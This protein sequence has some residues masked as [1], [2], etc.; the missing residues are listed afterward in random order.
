MNKSS[1][2]DYNQNRV[3]HIA[4]ASPQSSQSDSDVNLSAKGDNTANLSGHK[5][6]II[7]SDQRRGCSFDSTR[8]L[9]LIQGVLAA[10]GPESKLKQEGNPCKG[11]NAAVQRTIHRVIRN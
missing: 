1:V 8:G 2:L 10:S 5:K 11:D 9:V 6:L 4:F 3:N 7:S